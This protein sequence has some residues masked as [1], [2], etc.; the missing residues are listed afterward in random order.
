MCKDDFTE[1]EFKLLKAI[2][3]AAEVMNN[4][5]TEY[6]FYVDKSLLYNLEVKLGIEDLI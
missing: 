6:P 1:E 5:F 4:I 3:G 2:F